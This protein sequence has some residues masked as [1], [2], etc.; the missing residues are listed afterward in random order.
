MEA[1][2]LAK[3][4]ALLAN[5]RLVLVLDLDQTV[6]H[7]ALLPGYE[8]SLTAKFD[9]PQTDVHVFELSGPSRML[10]KFRPGLKQFLLAAHQL[11]EIH[12]YTMANAEY[13]AKIVD[14]I[15]TK[16][17]SDVEPS[18]RPQI[19]G[20]RII[21]RSHTE[22]SYE[23]QLKQQ[24]GPAYVMKLR[25]KRKDIK[26]IIGD[27][28]IAV[29]LDDSDGVWPDYLD[30]LIQIYPFVYWPNQEDLNKTFH[31]RSHTLPPA[32]T[33]PSTSEKTENLTN[34]SNHADKSEIIPIAPI[35]K[36]RPSSALLDQDMHFDSEE[37]LDDGVKR[38]KCAETS[39]EEQ[40]TEHKVA[41]EETENGSSS[42]PLNEEEQLL[43]KNT[44]IASHE[45][46]LGTNGSG[47][48]SQ[49][50]NES[51]SQSPNDTVSSAPAS[52][53][54]IKLQDTLE[55]TPS[56]V[57]SPNPVIDVHVMPLLLPF[58]IRHLPASNEDSCL[59]SMLQVLTRLHTE[60]FTLPENSNRRKVQLILPRLRE[61][62]LQHR[63]I[64]LSGVI[65][66]QPKP[67][68]NS[69]VGD[70]S[71]PWPLNSKVGM[72][73][74]HRLS[75]FGAEFKETITT[76]NPEGVTHVVS[77]R[78]STE[79][80][81]IAS[82][83]N[84]VYCVTKQWLDQSIIHWKAQEESKFQIPHIPL[85]NG[86]PL[87]P[88]NLSNGSIWSEKDL[89]MDIQ[90]HPTTNE[91]DIPIPSSPMSDSY[92]DLESLLQGDYDV[93]EEAEEEEPN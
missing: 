27:S 83:S 51:S 92:V 30:H 82:H 73:E 31:A 37:T 23:I 24:G 12:V 9:P 1:E 90:E 70:A 54:S 42:A 80:V 77:A 78:G 13:A 39:E 66:H 45:E 33:P 79:K 93:S 2:S 46:K 26:H 47:H 68:E 63:K 58:G 34:N 69:A 36:K 72:R 17:L 32:T 85:I 65:P 87:A 21:T 56:R 62:V 67:G 19:I 35:P 25:E 11:Y 41:N 28:S 6:L 75:A 8:G 44:S 50:M 3:K 89:A 60:F 16:I 52:L 38:R 10:V 76:G 5:Q 20:S 88:P 18:L 43:L 64:C 29:I 59:D 4:Q 91:G 40:A 22:D 71:P 61:Q 7:A 49:N 15:N 84:G 57:A 86:T 14:L 48:H 74:I 55:T 81:R 53:V